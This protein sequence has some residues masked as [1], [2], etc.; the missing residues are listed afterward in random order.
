MLSYACRHAFK[1][2]ASFRRRCLIEEDATAFSADDAYMPFRIDSERYV[3]TC[4]FTILLMLKSFLLHL[5]EDTHIKRHANQKTSNIGQP[6]PPLSYFYASYY[7]FAP[8]YAYF[9]AFICR[10]SILLSLPF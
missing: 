1:C 4:R 8:I 5:L 7:E 6:L 2:A 10:Q 3:I 9:Q